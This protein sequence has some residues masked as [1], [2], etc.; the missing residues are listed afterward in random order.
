MAPGRVLLVTDRGTS[1]PELRPM[2]LAL[3]QGEREVDVMN[4]L[5]FPLDP[6]SLMPYDA[7]I[8]ADVAADS[9]MLNQIQAMHDGIR[10]LGI[11]FMMVG[12]PNSFGPGGWQGSLIADALPISMEITNKKVLPKG[13]LAIILHTCEFPQGNTWAKRITKR[14]IQVLNS[15][16]LVELAQRR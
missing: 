11:G 8:F 3:R 13:A 7:V 16:D 5:E 10:N 1:S 4:S 2:E 15:E 12:G 9:L 6:L 14:A